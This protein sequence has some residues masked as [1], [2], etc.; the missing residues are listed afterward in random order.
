MRWESYGAVKSLSLLAIKLQAMST[1]V[2]GG[3][4]SQRIPNIQNG[5]VGGNWTVSRSSYFT[6]GKLVLRDLFDKWLMGR[7]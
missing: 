5:R 2:E 1:R 3:H 6:W 7:R 4:A